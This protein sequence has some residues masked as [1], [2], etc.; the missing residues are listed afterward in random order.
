MTAGTRNYPG[1]KF[2]D[3]KTS[4]L[5]LEKFQKIVA[6]A[7]NSDLANNTSFTQAALGKAADGTGTK[8]P[9]G[10]CIAYKIVATNLSNVALTNTIIS[11]QLPSDQ[12]R[13]ATL[14]ATPAAKLY[15][16]DTGSCTTTLDSASVTPGNNG[17]IKTQPF[18]LSATPNSKATLY[19]KIT[20][21]KL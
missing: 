16:S 4:L 20:Y 9:P 3:V 17:I 11:D 7:D 1:N 5:K 21:K 19:F 12:Q 2:D 18:N 8:V 14:M 10:S 6:C 15:L 13:Q